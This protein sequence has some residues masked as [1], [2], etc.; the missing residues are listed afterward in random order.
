M[1]MYMY[2]FPSI[3]SVKPV[4]HVSYPKSPDNKYK[5]IGHCQTQRAGFLVI[6]RASIGEPAGKRCKMLC[7]Y[8]YS[9]QHMM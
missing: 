5:V 8:S 3:A 2:N 4:G 9:T 7:L 1:P 6:T